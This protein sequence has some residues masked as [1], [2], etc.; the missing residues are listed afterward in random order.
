MPSNEKRPNTWGQGRPSDSSTPSQ[1][2]DN[3][4]NQDAAADKLSEFL[5]LAKKDTSRE[6]ERARAKA[7]KPK[8]ERPVV[9]L[10]TGALNLVVDGC[11]AVLIA[12]E[13]PI[14]ARGETLARA[15]PAPLEAGTVKRAAGALILTSVT[16][17]G[18]QDDLERV[19]EFRRWVASNDGPKPVRADAPAKACRALIERVGRWRFPQLRGIAMAPFIRADGSIASTP[20]YDVASG[21]LLAL[22]RDWP[23]PTPNP[24]RADAV[25]ALARLRHLIRT[26]QFV[27]PED[28]SVALAAMLTPLVRPGIAAAPMHGFS[29]PI[30]GSGKSML[31]DLVAIIATGRP[32]AALTWGPNQEENIKALTAVLLAGDAVAMLDNVEVP[33]RGELLCS[34]L[35]QRMLRLRPLG[36]S[37]LV[38]VPSVA[39]LLATGNALTPS[40]DMTRRVLVAE[41]DPQCERPEL[42]EFT[43]DPKA[44]AL[45]ARAELVNAGL[46]IITA[47]MRATFRRPPPLGSFEEWSRRVRDALIWLGMPDPVTVMERTFDGDPER[48][49]AI[50]VLAAWREVFGR[51][52]ATAAE[53]ARTATA[54]GLL[55]DSL[56]GIAGRAGKVS[57]KVLGRWLRRH[58]GR[59]MGGLKV[60][61]AGGDAKHGI[62]WKVVEH[63]NDGVSGVNGVSYTATREGGDESDKS[64][65][66]QS[67]TETPKTAETPSADDIDEFE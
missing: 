5:G 61:K 30:R 43:N 24:T 42:R 58:E 39:T 60:Q 14:Y 32:T 12:A 33:L 11:E 37:E 55:A 21:L 25:A 62:R 2:C 36:S 66:T 27:A 51:D 8:S 31:A 23:A 65:K 3:S 34:A 35:T 9:E 10:A 1:A 48:E 67:G 16:L 15:V 49:A 41:L 64:P 19:A 17:A 63:S 54:G 29:A 44:D 6:S 47:G 40:G 50:A 26:F 7:S 59:V 46:T 52:S 28:E 13:V 57:T 18:L 20:G 56:E 53:A 38:T 45:E 22:P 4:I